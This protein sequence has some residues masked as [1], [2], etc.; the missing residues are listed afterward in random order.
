LLEVDWPVVLSA[1]LAATLLA[2][3]VVALITARAFRRPTP[4]RYG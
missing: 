1:A 2:A 4:E 3:A